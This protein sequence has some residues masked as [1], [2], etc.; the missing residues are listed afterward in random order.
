MRAEVKLGMVISIIVVLVAGGY[1]IYR[2]R[3]E[4][5]IPMSDGSA[6]AVQPADNTKPDASATS[7]QAARGAQ[8]TA[9]RNKP[10]SAQGEGEK[11][12]R[13][14]P[15][16][17]HSEKRQRV[18]DADR[19]QTS[20][21]A[22]GDRSSP[23]RTPPQ[24]AGGT[25]RAATGRPN[26]V[27]GG[28][29]SDDV[30]Q[31]ANIP[32]TPPAAGKGLQPAQGA[33][34]AASNRVAGRS[35]DRQPA[36]RQRSNRGPSSQQTR[37]APGSSPLPAGGSRVALSGRQGT[38]SDNTTSAA[39]DTH[40]V[41]PGD[42]FSSLA[43]MYYGNA[44]HAQFLMDQNPEVGGPTRLAVGAVVKIPPLSIPVTGPSAEKRTVPVA[45]KSEPAPSRRTYTVKAG[46]T[47]YGIARDA[48]GDASRWR[49]LLRLN[50]KAIKGDPTRL[51]IGQVIVLPES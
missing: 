4:T 23:R 26:A 37:A 42:T 20:Q 40:R 15:G 22:A 17:S 19:K 27:P 36:T 28:Q 31:A 29:A 30:R 48:L 46:D 50:D 5:P 16:K 1:Y 35:S 24:E 18:A 8:R 2:D 10:A 9:D 12:R 44:K 25:K 43:Q 47:L 45:A 41:Q 6:S 51:Q 13:L 39:V 34:G 32:T 33:G 11:G 49:E 21:P 38:S 14:T 3:K 7:R